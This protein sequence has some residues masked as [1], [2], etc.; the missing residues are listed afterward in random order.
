MQE[1]IFKLRLKKWTEAVKLLDHN[2]DSLHPTEQDAINTLKN[3]WRTTQF[4]PDCT[5]RVERMVKLLSDSDKLHGN[6]RDIVQASKDMRGVA[7]EMYT[8][9]AE[10]F[11]QFADVLQK[12]GGGPRLSD[13]QHARRAES[14]QQPA[15]PVRPTRPTPPKPVRPA[16][17]SSSRSRPR[18]SRP[19]Q[20]IRQPSVWDNM[21]NSLS[22][23]WQAIAVG[24][25]V[26][27]LIGMGLAWAWKSGTAVDAYACD[28]LL[29][30][31]WNGEMGSRPA[32]LMID[33][34]RNDSLTARLF[35]NFKS[36]LEK[37]SL[38]GKVS[39][40]QEG[41]LLTMDNS[42]ST[43]H[44]GG[45]FRLFIARNGTS[46]RGNLF[47]RQTG[48]V[49]AVNLHN[50]KHRTRVSL[51][52]GGAPQ[53]VVDPLFADSVDCDLVVFKD[54][55]WTVKSYAKSLT[56]HKGELIDS[57]GQSASPAF[58]VFMNNGKHYRIGKSHLLWSKT[59]PDSLTNPLSKE[60][61]RRHSPYGQFLS[62]LWPCWLVIGFIAIGLLMSGIG[63]RFH[64][65]PVSQAAL[66]IMPLCLLA[67][68]A[69]ELAT[70]SLF[71]GKAFWWCDY[72]RYG[73]FGSMLRIVPFLLVVIAQVL[74]IW[75][76]EGL[77]FFDDSSDSKAIHLKPA[78]VGML[79]CIPA[80]AVFLIISQLAGWKG[81][82][83]EWIAA[84]L[85]L[86][87]LL[88]GIGIALKRN[89]KDIGVVKGILITAFSLIYIIGCFVAIGGLVV[90]IF[91][92]IF[93]ILCVLFG[94]AVL[95]GGS[96]SGRELYRD[97]AG[98][99]YRRVR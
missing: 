95:M 62:T 8:T 36:G 48:E 78:V 94:L 44:L 1:A 45:A 64:I 53:Y 47:G 35:V 20:P 81:N 41:C 29:Q 90:A 59:N 82:V 52:G 80:T 3:L 50:G 18:Q 88:T 4:G 31:E 12:T 23:S 63:L 68:A 91:Q 39:A 14:R 24:A 70:F 22:R 76:Y 56:L 66:V 58:I 10:T 97:R 93:Q 46:V 83:P 27:A 55:A 87:I 77:L 73:F 89:I 99:L 84:A 51:A 92:L 67:V 11:R 42:D 79:V 15:A 26:L 30:G 13:R 61:Q 96:S 19:V 54:S 69:I 33:T 85:F 17:P 49:T 38:T 40:Q 86:G 57:C 9:D 32:T 34:V 75:W 72:D 6:N 98:H 7:K 16:A 5:R 60:L 37:C 74:S 2:A 71:G 25:A 21:R 28:K 65:R 43:S